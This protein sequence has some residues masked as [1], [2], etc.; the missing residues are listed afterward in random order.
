MLLTLKVNL[1]L[2]PRIHVVYNSY[3][4]DGANLHHENTVSKKLS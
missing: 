3:C 2:Y 4:A 1:F